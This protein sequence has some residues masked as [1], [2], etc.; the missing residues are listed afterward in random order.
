MNNQYS[1]KIEWNEVYECIVSLYAFIDEKEQKHFHLGPEWK[2]RAVEMLPPAFARELA[3]ERW[4]VL[5]RLV[6]LAAQSPETTTVP[7]FLNWLEKL[8]AGD[9][10]ERLAPWVQTIPLDL[11]AVRD[12]I[13][14]VLKRWHEHYFSNLDPAILTT[15]AQSA[16]RLRERAETE[17]LVSAEL[18]DHATGGIWID[19]VPGLQ[20]VVLVPQYHCAPASVLDFYRGMATCLYPVSLAGQD[21]LLRELLPI[22][23]CLADAK[24][25][26]ILRFLASGS[27]TLGELQQHV[28][29]AKSTVH[30]H[31][32]VLRRAGLIRAHY[33]GTTTS[34]SCY[35][36]RESFLDHLPVILRT[37]LHRGG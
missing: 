9:I 12:H 16:A 34:V 10:Y 19:D 6:L 2:K 14:S 27:R 5:H 3:D 33:T 17:T 35:S 1:I 4:E 18:I 29:L 31:V 7:S 15:L 23:Q 20:Q 28:G 32:T 21:D 25:L 22:T 8:P 11:A 37:Y 13:L 24:R 26:Q 36:L 30:H